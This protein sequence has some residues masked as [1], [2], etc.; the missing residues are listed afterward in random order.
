L[1]KKGKGEGGGEKKKNRFWKSA[2]RFRKAKFQGRKRGGKEN[3]GRREVDLM[4]SVFWRK[5]RG[6]KVRVH[7]K[8]DSNETRELGGGGEKGGGID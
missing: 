6:E 4:R 5:K 3:G 8:Y 7:V 2:E 1:R